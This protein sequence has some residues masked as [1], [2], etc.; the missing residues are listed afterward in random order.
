VRQLH[1]SRMAASHAWRSR[2]SGRA[3][4]PTDGRSILP[5]GLVARPRRHN[6]RSGACNPE[7]QLGIEQTVAKADHRR[8]ATSCTTGATPPLPR[9]W[10]RIEKTTA[11]LHQ[12][13]LQQTRSTST[14]EMLDRR[15]D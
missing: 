12:R 10:I 5:I 7:L 11:S 1:I 2:G 6:S 3:S 9:R 4:P 8:R 13:G 14:G 15:A